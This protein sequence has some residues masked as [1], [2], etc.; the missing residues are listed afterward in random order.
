MKVHYDIMEV[1]EETL[2]KLSIR[3]KQTYK[4]IAKMATQIYF[5][6]KVVSPVSVF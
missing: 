2:L 3:V 1:E 5:Y 4:Q 6:S